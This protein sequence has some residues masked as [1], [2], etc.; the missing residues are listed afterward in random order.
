[1]GE[2]LWDYSES[3][4]PILTRATTLLKSALHI[5]LPSKITLLKKGFQLLKLKSQG[6][7]EA[8]IKNVIPYEPFFFI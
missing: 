3:P 7:F 5:G 8:N 1:M 6:S 4:I 2:V